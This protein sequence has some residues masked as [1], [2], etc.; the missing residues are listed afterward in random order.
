[1]DIVWG[2]DGD[3]A[4]GGLGFRLGQGFRLGLGLGIRLGLGLGFRLGLGLGPWL[5]LGQ[6]LRAKAGYVVGPEVMGDFI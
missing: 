2:I 4:R 3:E 1:M 5:E 6:G